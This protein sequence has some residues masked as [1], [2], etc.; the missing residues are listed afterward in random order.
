MR[1]KAQQKSLQ[2]YPPL[3]K[4]KGGSNIDNAEALERSRKQPAE[5]LANFHSGG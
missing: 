1:N 2:Q 3:K 4:L 5:I